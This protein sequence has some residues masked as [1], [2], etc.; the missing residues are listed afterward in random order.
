MKKLVLKSFLLLCCLALTFVPVFHLI[1][2]EFSDRFYHKFTYKAPSLLLGSS[3]AL[4]G[5][6]PD[7]INAKK[8]MPPPILNFGF[9]QAT[10]PYGEVYYNAIMKKVGTAESKGVFILEVGP[11]SVSSKSDSIAE[12][13]LI[14][15]RLRVFNANPNIDY[16]LENS[17]NPL[18]LFLADPQTGKK[19]S[20][21]IYHTNGWN[22]SG[23]TPDS[24]TMV[25]NRAH[26]IKAYQPVFNGS[27]LSTYRL[28]WLE[29][30]VTSLS[31]YGKVVLVRVPVTSEMKKME[32]VYCPGFNDIMKQLAEK[33]NALYLDMMNTGD[34]VFLDIHHLSSESA[35]VFSERLGD[36]LLKRGFY[37]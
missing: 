32:D 26:G 16:I 19:K 31:E 36:T 2:K 10:S 5:L 29:K 1:S 21:A 24:L 6:N 30:T 17:Q 37:N 23:N 22:Q 11:L 4:L 25:A 13:K 8:K 35:N 20:K 27:S 15:G 34:Y 9:T 3:R 28:S 7:K 18:Y 12:G 14:L 33:K